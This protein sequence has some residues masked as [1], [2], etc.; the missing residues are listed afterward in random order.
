ME[1]QR[2]RYGTP[3]CSLRCGREQMQHYD[4]NQTQNNANGGINRID[5]K[6]HDQ[7]AKQT[8]KTRVPREVFEKW[9]EIRSTSQFN[10]QA[11]EISCQIRKHK[12]HRVN[13]RNDIERS[14]Q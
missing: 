2:L 8:D 13:L 9:P 12:E 3:L 6:H 1:H 11:S 7:R 14:N 10:T 4:Q 5:D